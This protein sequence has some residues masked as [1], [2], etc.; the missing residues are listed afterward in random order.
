MRP[1]IREVSVKEALNR[2][3]GMPFSW[4]LN[5]YRGC[6]HACV[7]CYAR[8][9]HTYLNLGAGEDFSRILFVKTN[10]ADRLR[11][12]L[13]RKTWAREEVAV[14]S[15]TD[16]YQPIEGR[17]RVTRACLEALADFKTPTSVITKGTL[18]Q[19]DLD[20]LQELDRV[21]RVTVLFS[22][23]TINPE[24][25]RKTEPGTPPPEKRLLAMARL[26]AHGIRAGVM[27]A[28]ILFGISDAET[29]LRR[30]A[31]AARAYGAAFIHAAGVRLDP[32]VR[33]GYFAFIDEFY[34]HLSAPYRLWY[35][36]GTNP[37]PHLRRQLEA[38]MKPYV[39][40]R[41]PPA[42]SAPGR[43]LAFRWEEAAL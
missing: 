16:P 26:R 1:E 4:S 39:T 5:P 28:P 2:V 30:T 22:V 23:P 29:E 9:T 33:Q 17:F 27:M 42:P 24:I 31:E 20:V 6:Q 35:R 12:E 34:P 3:Q 36:G 40:P 19:R 10:L 21:A 13:G 11:A 14:G 25:W 32:V 15:A 43:Q 8:T 41:T 37:P 38:R 18:I 7:Y